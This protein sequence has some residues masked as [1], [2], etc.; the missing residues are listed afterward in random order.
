MARLLSSATGGRGNASVWRGSAVTSA[1]GVT[2]ARLVPCRTA[3]RAAS[4]STT[5]TV[6]F[7]NSS[8]STVITRVQ[9]APLIFRKQN[10]DTVWFK[11]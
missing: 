11:I 7:R 3:N 8:V 2:E 9:D 6:S 4:A 1:T 5:G 10:G